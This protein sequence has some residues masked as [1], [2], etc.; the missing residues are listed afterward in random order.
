MHWSRVSR[1]CRATLLWR[2]APVARSAAQEFSRRFHVTSLTQLPDLRMS[3]IQPR[4]IRPPW[5]GTHKFVEFS[6][7]IFAIGRQ[8]IG[9]GLTRNSI[10][11]PSRQIRH[12]NMHSVHNIPVD[13]GSRRKKDKSSSSFLFFLFFFCFFFVDTVVTR[14]SRRFVA[15]PSHDVHRDADHSQPRLPHVSARPDR[16]ALW[17]LG[18]LLPPRGH[19]L[20]AGHHPLPNRRYGLRRA[21]YG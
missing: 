16:F 14:G 10:S 18:L 15:I 7:P 17:H 20:P 5:H 8:G 4:E 21:E 13:N 12:S 6:V 2:H 3:A 11:I 1:V 9:G 19:A